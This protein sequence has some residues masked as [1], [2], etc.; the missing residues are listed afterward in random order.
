MN[1]D[2]TKLHPK[3]SLVCLGVFCGVLGALSPNPVSSQTTSTTLLEVLEPTGT[4]LKRRVNWYN[5]SSEISNN[6]KC[7]IPQ[8][9]QLNITSY[10]RPPEGVQPIREVNPSSTYYGNI[11]YPR[12]YWEVTLVNPPRECRNQQNGGRGPWFVYAEHIRIR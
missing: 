11:E 12:D 3:K 1:I 5:Q 8:G 10:R 4:H 2:V 7:Y 9:T 6:L